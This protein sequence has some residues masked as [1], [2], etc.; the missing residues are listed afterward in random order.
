MK[1]LVSLNVVLD[2]DEVQR[3]KKAL[4][5]ASGTIPTTRHQES[6]RIAAD[7]FG[8]CKPVEDKELGPCLF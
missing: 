3:I 4:W 2:L 8:R 7:I 1:N 6:L 5:F